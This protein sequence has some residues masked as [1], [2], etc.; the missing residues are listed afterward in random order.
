[1]IPD[2][3]LRAECSE[4]M[5]KCKNSVERWNIVHKKATNFISSRDFKKRKSNTFLMME[6]MLQFAYPR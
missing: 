4:A 6:I 2:E 1:M 5:E 3:D